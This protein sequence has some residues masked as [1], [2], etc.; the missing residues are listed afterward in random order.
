MTGAIQPWLESV[1]LLCGLTVVV[2]GVGSVLP[3]SPIEPFLLGLA[4][5]VPRHVLLPVALVAT[6]GHMGGKVLLY[7]GARDAR[8][9]LRARH[10]AA[11][12]RAG[13]HLARR[14]PL[15][16]LAVLVSACL[17]VPPFYAVTLACGA[18]HVPLGCFLAAGTVGRAVRF[19]GLVLVPQLF[20]DTA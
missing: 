15:Q 19:A 11:V 5:V 7:L 3:F 9:A 20:R 10:R 4:A 18:L 12:E 1:P 8:H 14:R 6:L 17:G 13:A 16:Y 2:A